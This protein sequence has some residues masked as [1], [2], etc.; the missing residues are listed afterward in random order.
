VTT[1]SSG[2]CRQQVSR[3]SY[4][5]TLA[6][7][8]TKQI[9][10]KADLL[11]E[12]AQP[13]E[14]RK[15]SIPAN[16]SQNLRQ[17]ISDP[18]STPLVAKSNDAEK[19]S[20]ISVP[21]KN[22]S[23]ADDATE[24]LA[25][26]S[27]SIPAE[28]N[29]MEE[30]DQSHSELK[31]EMEE[32]DN[33]VKTLNDLDANVTKDKEGSELTDKPA[34][35]L[36][37]FEGELKHVT[38]EFGESTSVQSEC[39]IELDNAIMG[40]MDNESPEVEPATTQAEFEDELI[41]VCE[42]SDDTGLKD[43][44]VVIHSES[45]D[46]FKLPVTEEKDD[47][48]IEKSGMGESESHV[49]E[50]K[51]SMISSEFQ[52]E[53]TE[54][55]DGKPIDRSMPVVVESK[56][57]DDLNNCITEENDTELKENDELAAAI[58]A[59]IDDEHMMSIELRTEQVTGSDVPAPAEAV[60]SPKLSADS[61]AQ[62][63]ESDMEQTENDELA[64]AIQSAINDERMMSIEY[65]T[66]QK[67]NDEIAAAI[68]SAIDDERMMS[69]EPGAELLIGNDEPAAAEAVCSSK[70]KTDLL[71]QAETG[72]GSSLENETPP[73]R[74]FSRSAARQKR[75]TRSMSPYSHQH[76]ISQKVLYHSDSGMTEL[77][78]ETPT[79]AEDSELEC[80]QQNPDLLL[81]LSEDSDGGRVELTDEEQAPERP[82]VKDEGA[83][84]QRCTSVSFSDYQ[85]K[86]E[87]LCAIIDCGFEHPTEVQHEC[88][89]QAILGTDIIC[90][91]K[92]GAG[93]MAVFVLATLQQ[94]EPVD[95]EVSV[96]VMC[97]T[98]ELA[99]HVSNEY[100]RFS[101][102]MNTVKI[103]VFIGGTVMEKD[104]EVLRNNCPHIV[105]GT[106]GRIQALVR[107][108]RLRL[109]NLKHFVLGDCDKMLKQR[110]M[111]RD[112]QEIFSKTSESKQVML[113][114][115]TLSS[116]IRTVCK[117]F[118][119]D[120]VEVYMDIHG[121]VHSKSS[122]AG[123][124][125]LQSSE[126][127]VIKDEVD[128]PLPDTAEQLDQSDV[129]SDEKAE[130]QAASNSGK[131]KYIHSSSF[132]DFHLKP[133]LLR[134]IVDCGFEH[135]TEV[136]HECIPQ[137]ILGTDIIC[138][139]KSGAGKT[140]VFVLA[141]LQQ[142]EPV[143]G[144]VSVLVMCHTRE[145]A[146]HISDEYERFSKYMNTVKIAMFIGGTVIEKDEE[147]LGNN[148]PHIVVGTPGRI[149]ALVR[150]GRLLSLQNLKHFVLADCHTMLNPLV[151]DMHRDIQ[152]IFHAT[153]LSK[154]VMLFSATLSKDIR[155]L[156]KKFVQNPME[157]YVGDGTKLSQV[158]ADERE[159]CR[160][161]RHERNLEP[162]EEGTFTE[163]HGRKKEI[164]HGGRYDGSDGRHGSAGI[165]ETSS[166]E[167]G[168][169]IKHKIGL[170][171]R[172]RFC[173]AQFPTTATL[174]E[175]LLWVKHQQVCEISFPEMQLIFHKT[176]Q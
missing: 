85:L 174:L 153:P 114:S 29:S 19:S 79:D 128:T 73:A 138:Q 131:I 173:R 36:S 165:E 44:S 157:V 70:L 81:V 115:A 126:K 100:E 96:L 134:A 21:A 120:L 98:C 102:Y 48:L 8:R 118:V 106:P 46:Q 132:H 9:G 109:Q 147:V 63:R 62:P 130:Q 16:D 26:A 60:C 15:Y 121:H 54:E 112:I 110:D 49:M 55:K 99:L 175:H 84:S 47:E 41:L 17:M 150:L 77:E 76:R 14:E 82:G 80:L 1:A 71:P 107:L 161:R 160:Q 3:Y 35:I 101:K 152:Q 68:Q 135:P 158:A 61:L 104:E 143:D 57:V 125:E 83:M 45:E 93:K 124:D 25:N 31:H 64:D 72:A 171:H 139:A 5:I 58:Q 7:R 94:L 168:A 69:V 12:L 2:K 86:P 91:A 105:V 51:P 119:Q 22:Q 167:G 23:T 127:P 53:L 122:L 11:R 43:N 162:L 56:S 74:K 111:R 28:L 87:L 113:F 89:P 52:D 123:G 92:S 20:V 27:A 50:V 108:G 142:L 66:E 18:P 164:H 176:L 30:K 166:D 34:V 103:A 137:A 156:C 39:Q 40:E 169:R 151:P 97:H 163:H 24:Q 4:N 133:E 75:S 59:A 88:I 10:T 149:R 65:G 32:M 95:G 129:A 155:P 154:Q 38:E 145:L 13:A 144:E 67:E 117:K 42:E 146:L 159:H 90:Q 141:T 78:M 170:G 33:V 148:C 172:C 6:E 136:Q 116:D 37:E 140:A